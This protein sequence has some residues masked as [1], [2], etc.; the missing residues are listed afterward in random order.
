[1]PEH[2]AYDADLKT[3][4]AEMKKNAA[5]RIADPG[6]RQRVINSLEGINETLAGV[7]K[8]GALKVG[9]KS[10]GNV[11]VSKSLKGSERDSPKK[12]LPKSPIMCLRKRK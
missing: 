7:K 9:K 1:M 6:I 2:N 11:S 5:T 3:G 10:D 8:K 4:L 12:I